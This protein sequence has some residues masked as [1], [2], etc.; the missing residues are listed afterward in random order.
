M[1]CP[2]NKDVIAICDLMPVHLLCHTLPIVM[3]Y[4]NIDDVTPFQL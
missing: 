2:N 3:P 4:V 1:P